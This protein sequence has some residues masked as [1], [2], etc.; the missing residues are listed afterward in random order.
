ML[1][2]LGGCTAEVVQVVQRRD[3]RAGRRAHHAAGGGPRVGGSCGPTWATGPQV[4][5]LRSGTVLEAPALIA[6]FDDVTMMGQAIEQRSGHLGVAEDR[7]LART[8]N[9]YTPSRSRIM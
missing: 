9:P 5:R 6:G 3:P 8:S 7:I 2:P 4:D 1:A